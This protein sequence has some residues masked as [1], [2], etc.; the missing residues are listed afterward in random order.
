[1]IYNFILIN[2]QLKRP[3]LRR[4]LPCLSGGREIRTLETREGLPAFQAG[5]LG[6][7]AIPPFPFNFSLSAHSAS[8]PEAGAPWAH[9]R[10][11]Q[12]SSPPLL[13]N[14]KATT[15]KRFELRGAG[16]GP[17]LNILLL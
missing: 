15:A 4:F 6:H 16:E 17:V 3:T 7:Y 12:S 1:M 5:A 9:M 13:L 14:R 8:P 11:L 10:S 2:F